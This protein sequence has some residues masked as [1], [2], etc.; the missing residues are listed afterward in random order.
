MKIKVTLSF[1]LL[2]IIL[3][4]SC[5]SFG[6]DIPKEVV[7]DF[8]SAFKDNDYKTMKSYMA[9]GICYFDMESANESKIAALTLNTIIKNFEYE[10]KNSNILNDDSAVVEVE[11][12]NI[13]MYDIME[14]SF[15]E[16]NE[17]FNKTNEELSEDSTKDMD[18]EQIIGI[19]ENKIK[20]YEM[21]EKFKTTVKISLVDVSDSW[22]VVNDTDMF[23]G[24]TGEY[25]SFISRGLRNF[26]S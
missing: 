17:R 19:L 18:E 22:K 21:K 9:D 23:D 10:I 26:V 6:K 20:E 13:H 14:D 12:T 4:F 2:T 16:Y 8:L 5:C 15:F 1:V 7:E 11:M 24:M 25:V 3:C